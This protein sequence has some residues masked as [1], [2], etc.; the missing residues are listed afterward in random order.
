MEGD[1]GTKTIFKLL[2][3]GPTSRNVHIRE[4]KPFFKHVLIKKSSVFY[5]QTMSS[6]RLGKAIR[7]DAQSIVQQSID[8][9]E[10]LK[11]LV[12]ENNHLKERVRELG[13]IDHGDVTSVFG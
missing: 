2:T 10:G 9:T 13:Q 5:L 7:I 3:S 12:K 11:E 1:E 8:L 6:F 4:C